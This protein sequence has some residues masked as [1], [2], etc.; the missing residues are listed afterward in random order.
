[1]AS[2]SPACT[3]SPPATE[4]LVTTPAD[5]NVRSALRSAAADP[6]R[7]TV[8]VRLPVVATTCCGSTTTSASSEPTSSTTA[9][10]AA[11]TTTAP[12]GSNE[13]QRRRRPR[14]R[15][16]M[17]TSVMLVPRSRV[18]RWCGTADK[19]AI[20]PDFPDRSPVGRQAGVLTSPGE[21]HD[22]SGFKSAGSRRIVVAA[23][24]SIV[25][26]LRGFEGSATMRQGAWPGSSSA[27]VRAGR[28]PAAGRRQPKR[29]P[30][31]GV[32]ARFSSPL[33]RRFGHAV[34]TRLGSGRPQGAAAVVDERCEGGSRRCHGSKQ[35]SPGM[36]S[37][38][39][40]RPARWRPMP[41]RSRAPRP[42]R[43]F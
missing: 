17:S 9:T 38:V 12:A 19:P 43:S 23:G 41:R 36:S 18:S 2:V 1:M 3:A 8:V 35:W 25:A 14:I 24:W 33:A 32:P 6:D 16:S 37:S 10:T 26:R 5:S 15:A 28:S 34:A 7:S 40:T 31:R 21:A 4:R 42:G 30:E 22:H 13:R 11:A 27:G 39:A 20:K 29:P